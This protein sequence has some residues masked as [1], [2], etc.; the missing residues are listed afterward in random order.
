METSDKIEHVFIIGEAGV[1]HNGDINLAKE[2]IDVAV[3]AQVDAVK[4]QTFKPGEITGKFAVKSGYMNNTTDQDDNRYEVSRKLALTYDE[5]IELKNYSDKKNVLFLT[6]PDGFES[7][8]FVV[9]ELNIRMIKLGSTELNNLEFIK[10]AA[11]KDRP[12]IL[13][14][15]MGT[16]GEVERAVEI[17]RRYNSKNLTILQCT[18]E[19]PAPYDEINLRAMVTMRDAL[20]VDVGFS[21][22][23][24]GIV[25]SI[26]AVALG[27]KVIEKH[28]TVDKSLQ[29]P[30]HKA[31][32]SP[33]ELKELVK[34][35]RIAERIRGNGIK[36]PSPSEIANMA[37]I[38]RGLV[39]AYD[40]KK[41]VRLTKNMLIAKRPFVGIEPGQID[42]LV[43]MRLNKDLL[44][45]DEP[46]HWDDVK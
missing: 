31:S 18:S 26:S 24:E 22:H 6:T 14:T 23:T 5:F 10:E 40:L 16:L 3:E 15:G 4:F 28:F 19:Y 1:N 36:R 32:M 27:A 37:S 7:L 20:Q 9:N 35:I 43:G 12:I 21:D 34:S 44:L 25:A 8:D 38:R 29:G 33:D 45:K 41:G 17:I 42:I 39:A 11:K 30:D 13:S 2:L 46:I